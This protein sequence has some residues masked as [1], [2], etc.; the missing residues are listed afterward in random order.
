M[1]CGTMPAPARDFAGKRILKVLAMLLTYGFLFS[2]LTAL[3][4]IVG[5]TLIKVAADN[6]ALP[7]RQMA[8]GILFYASSAICWYFAMRHMT[9]AEAA[10]AYSMLTLVALCAI[11]ALVFG[12]PLGLREALGV[13][14]AVA[15]MWVMSHQA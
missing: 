14:L 10:V 15:A 13:S 11:G 3:L 5:D 8:G 9:L 12:E 4:V 6:A 7:S 1:P 2:L